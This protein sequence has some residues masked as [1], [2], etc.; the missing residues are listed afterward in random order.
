MLELDDEREGQFVWGDFSR[1]DAEQ[2]LKDG[3]ITVYSSYPIKSGVFVSTSYVQAQE[4]AGGRNGKVYS[5]TIPLTDVAWINGDEGQYASVDDI[6]DRYSKTGSSRTNNQDTLEDR[7]SG[8]EL[9]DAQDLIEVVKEKGG[10]VNENGYITLYHRT[11]AENAEKIRST[12]YMKGKED[13][14]FFSTTKEGYASGYGDTI[15]EFSIPAEKL[16]LDDIFDNEAHL[17]LPMKQAGMKNVRAYLVDENSDINIR[18]SKT[19]NR[20]DNSGKTKYNKGRKAQ[21][22]PYSKVGPDV[23]RFIRFELSKLYANNDGVATEIAIEKGN[24]VYI[25]DSGREKGKLSFGIR[26][27]ITISDD[28]VRFEYVRRM[29]YDAISK[30]HVSDELSSEF[31][32]RY[33]NDRRSDRR[34]ESGTEL[35][36]DS[37]KSS[38][39]EKGILGDDGLRGINDRSSKTGKDTLEMS[40]GEI[41]KLRANYMSDKV[42]NEGKVAEALNSI[43]M[44]KKIP[45]KICAEMLNRIWTGFN[46]HRA[47][48]RYIEVTTERL[49]ATIMQ[50]TDFELYELDVKESKDAAK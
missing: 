47:Y 26:K 7:V 2:A 1:A 22:I 18:Y 6:N 12:G 41:E 39:N 43:P 28:R 11:S 20:V 38:N 19:G 40:R 5:K 48:D 30:G 37:R 34:Q 3:T 13:G 50:E 45:S 44:F 33:A 31:E 8:D 46:E 15:V 10:I 36:T 4:Y 25:V 24:V 27:K 49:Y 23:V 16:V 42:F 32:G 35:Q 9:L 21:Y 29:N 14:L 17:K